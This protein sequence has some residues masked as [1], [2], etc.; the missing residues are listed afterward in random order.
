MIIFIYRRGEGTT[1]VSLYRR[2]APA[3]GCE[4]VYAYVA[5]YMIMMDV[6]VS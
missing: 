4:L 1:V 2:T 6:D 5:F 3:D